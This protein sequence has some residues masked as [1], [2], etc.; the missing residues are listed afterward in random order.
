M[1]KHRDS[2]IAQLLRSR[3][4]D[5]RAHLDCAH[6]SQ[7]MS[8]MKAAT[9]WS[10][11]QSGWPRRFPIVQFPNPPLLVALVGWGLADAFGGTTHE[12]GRTVFALGLVVW[13]CEEVIGGVNWFRRLLGAGVLVWLILELAG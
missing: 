6:R 9:A 7:S 1:I 5:P 8:A 12:I 13:A 10:R 2:G 3:T 11:G 4:D